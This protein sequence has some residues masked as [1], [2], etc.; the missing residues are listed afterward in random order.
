MINIVHLKTEDEYLYLF[1]KQ[2]TYR[3]EFT[4]DNFDRY[5]ENTHVEIENEEF[6]M[7]GKSPDLWIERE[8]IRVF[9]FEGWC[10]KN[11]Y[12]LVNKEEFMEAKMLNILNKTYDNPILRRTTVPLFMSNP[13]IGK[14][15]IT[16]EFIKNFVESK[17]NKMVTM[18]LPNLM[19]N[20]AVGGVYPNQETK[21]WEFYD[22]EKLS[23]LKDGDVLFLDEVF[24]GTLKQTLDAMLNV[25]G[26]RR[27]GSGK[28]MADVMIV[29]ASNPQGLINLT[30]QIKER[31]IRYDLKFNKEEYQS[32][33]KA[34][35]GMPE[36][37]SNNLCILINKETFESTLW[38]FLTPRSIEKAINQIGCDLESPYSDILL[39]YLSQ[40]IQSP[41]DISALGVAKG[42]NVP[43]LNI[44]KLF[45][46]ND[47]KNKIKKS[48]VTADLSS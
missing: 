14:T 4:E 19:P 12:K 16:E 8:E 36:K 7:Y 33:L 38:D 9:D 46:K 27:L 26:Q 20:E 17:G 25:L 29:A 45:I 13:G 2:S 6:I 47:N 15:K 39:P 41:M 31:F 3:K 43:Y 11:K 37:I 10:I 30:P 21:V 18:V 40:E 22:S 23:N 35:Y 5:K 42:E 34:K 44:L 28:M 48:R 1:R 24:N 32:Y